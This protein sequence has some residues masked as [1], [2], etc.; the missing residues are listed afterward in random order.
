ME[1]CYLSIDKINTSG[2]HLRHFRLKIEASCAHA[3]L[4]AHFFSQYSIE[5]VKIMEINFH[6]TVKFMLRVTAFPYRKVQDRI[7]SLQFLGKQIPKV[8]SWKLSF[9]FQ[10]WFSAACTQRCLC[11]FGAKFSL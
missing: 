8:G 11:E 6:T 3:N 5:K 9:I 4:R 7:S 10:S 2:S 1:S